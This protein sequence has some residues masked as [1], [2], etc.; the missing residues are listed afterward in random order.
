MMEADNMTVHCMYTLICIWLIS[1]FQAFI[2]EGVSKVYLLS[3][4]YLNYG[5]VTLFFFHT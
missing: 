5:V 3:L 1:S 2:D 4:L